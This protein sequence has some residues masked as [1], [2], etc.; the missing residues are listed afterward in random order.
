MSECSSAGRRVPAALAVITVS[1]NKDLGTV[2][3]YV[4][5]EVSRVPRFRGLVTCVILFIYCSVLGTCQA[6]CKYRNGPVNTEF[7]QVPRFRGLLT[8]IVLYIYFS[9][10][11]TSASLCKFTGGPS[12]VM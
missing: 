12:K 4:K 10:L 8:Y 7:S 6:L 3:L 9:V 2:P 11:V 1:T 5:S